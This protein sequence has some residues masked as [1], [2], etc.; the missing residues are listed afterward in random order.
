MFKDG[1]KYLAIVGWASYFARAAYMQLR[2]LTTTP[3]HR[4]SIAGLAVSPDS[5]ICLANEPTDG[6]LGDVVGELERVGIV[7]AIDDVAIGADHQP[8]EIPTEARVY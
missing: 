1:A 2:S 5:Q 6:V 7:A 8:A 3:N 4:R